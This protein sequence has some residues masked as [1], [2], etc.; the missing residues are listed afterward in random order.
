MP[1]IN[2]QLRY[3]PYSIKLISRSTIVNERE[4]W[5]P[6]NGLAWTPQP[7][8]IVKLNALEGRY[9]FYDVIDEHI[10]DISIQ[11]M[12]AL[13]EALIKHGVTEHEDFWDDPHVP[14][15]ASFKIDITLHGK[16]YSTVHIKFGMCAYGFDD[17]EYIPH[18]DYVEYSNWGMTR[19]MIYLKNNRQ[20]DLC[21]A[22]RIM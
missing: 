15:N 22:T 10:K 1:Y 4:P 11:T 9:N 14:Y 5:E 7:A 17:K 13:K 18:L 16:C 20:K 8:K 21:L 12:Y 6:L 2:T 19:R 3:E